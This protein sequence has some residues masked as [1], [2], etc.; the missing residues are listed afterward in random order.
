ME[1]RD[2][3]TREGARVNPLGQLITKSIVEAELEE[4]SERGLAFSW[5]TGNQ[6]IDI[7]DTLL[8]VQNTGSDPLHLVR[9]VLNGDSTNPMIY[10]IGLGSETT[11]PAGGT[12]LTAIN[13]NHIF[14][15]VLPDAIA[16]TDETAVADAIAY[17]RI[18]ML[19]DVD[20]VVSMV[21]V[22]LGKNHYIQI[23]CETEP[24]AV[25]ATLVGHY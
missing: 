12:L 8:F 20:R 15:S 14:S 19:A 21:G 18:K 3:L 11:T 6:N 5:Y 4:A 10:D 23:N 7:N 22:I 24:A 1:I 16:R 13:I 9:L 2:P 25:S 17:T